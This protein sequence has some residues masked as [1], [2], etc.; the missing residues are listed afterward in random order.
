MSAYRK[1]RSTITA[2]A[3]VLAAFSGSAFAKDAV[4]ASVTIPPE[5]PVPVITEN[6]SGYTPGT[7]ANGTIQLDY[8]HVGTTFTA[9]HFATFN[10]ALNVYGANDARNE[11]AYPVSL[12]LEQ[13][14]ADHLSLVPALPSVQVPGPVWTQVVPVEISI[15]VDVASDPEWA[16]DGD[17]LVGNLRL[18]TPGGSQL[19]T[20]T[21]IQI[22]I[23]LAHPTACIKVYN[24]ITDDTLTHTVTGIEVKVNAQQNKVTSTN[25]Y[26]TLSSNVLIVNTCGVPESFDLSAAL[27]GWFST[28]P[29][30]NP[31]NA[32]FTYSNAGEIDPA[33]FDIA[34]FGS[35]T[36][37]G[38]NLCLTDVSLPPGSSFLATVKMSINKGSSAATLPGAGVFDGFGAT[39]YGANSACGGSPLG[40]ASPNPVDAPLTFTI[41]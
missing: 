20:V 34:S 26:G 2:T 33:A 32:V 8:V 40:V 23:R 28:Q 13:I 14:G 7:Y 16:Q 17:Q 15:P 11:P 24:F 9:G 25:P 37:Q 21:N 1:F 10:V 38:Q 35:G 27:D 39:L 4:Q 29:S 5:Q 36:P 30:N 22:K 3:L 41:K 18:V 12:A 31:G 19:D 6:G